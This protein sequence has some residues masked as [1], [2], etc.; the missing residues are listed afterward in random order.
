MTW[1]DCETAGLY[2]STGLYVLY[3]TYKPVETYKTYNLYNLIAMGRAMLAMTTA[4][5]RMK[6]MVQM[7]WFRVA[8]QLLDDRIAPD[9]T[10]IGRFGHI[11]PVGN[12]VE[13]GIARRS[14]TGRDPLCPQ[15]S[16]LLGGVTERDESRGHRVG[17]RG[18]VRGGGPP[19]HARQ[20]SSPMAQF[21]PQEEFA[22]L[23]AKSS[24]LVVAAP[25][26]RMGHPGGHPDPGQG[27]RNCARRWRFLVA[28]CA[29]SSE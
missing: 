21:L 12:V 22:F 2:V 8:E 17:R 1:T 18:G 9:G 14:P 4:I 5:P 23:R 10:D 29:G 16:A 25:A 11:A 13:A 7:G 26:L 20:H 24:L 6:S 19:R 3:R 27:V 15:R 28:C